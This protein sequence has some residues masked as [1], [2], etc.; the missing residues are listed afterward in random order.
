MLG[1]GEIA[2]PA[3]QAGSLVAGS[4]IGRPGRP[5]ALPPRLTAADLAAHAGFVGTLGEAPLWSRY[6]APL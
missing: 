1:L 4:G 5:A 6:E 3:A 2:V